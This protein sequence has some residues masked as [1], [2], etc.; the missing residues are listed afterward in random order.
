MSMGMGMG[1]GMGMV[2]AWEHFSMPSIHETA[3]RQAFDDIN[4]HITVAQSTQNKWVSMGRINRG[5]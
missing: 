2:V 4:T 5:T 1:M 3:N